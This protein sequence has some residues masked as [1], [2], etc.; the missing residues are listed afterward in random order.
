MSLGGR[1]AT[2]VLIC[3]RVRKCSTAQCREATSGK[4]GKSERGALAQC[5]ARMEK[6]Y[7]GTSCAYLVS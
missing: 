4:N 6:G 1:S 7:L 2:V 5:V 3:P